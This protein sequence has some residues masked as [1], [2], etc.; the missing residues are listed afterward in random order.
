MTK[1]IKINNCESCPYLCNTCIHDKFPKDKEIKDFSVID[2]DCPLDDQIS[3][4]KSLPEFLFE[5][6]ESIKFKH[7]GDSIVTREWKKWLEKHNLYV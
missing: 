6:K 7:W 5:E 1:I 4:I 2:S 3:K